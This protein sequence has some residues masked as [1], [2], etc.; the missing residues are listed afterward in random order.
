MIIEHSRIGCSEYIFIESYQ[1]FC[2]HYEALEQKFL[3]KY[4][5]SKNYVPKSFPCAFEVKEYNEHL[6]RYGFREYLKPC[7]IT[8]A[9]HHI[10]DEWQLMIN[11]QQNRINEINNFYKN[12]CETT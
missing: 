6:Y 7:D 12:F 9:Y 5:L 8:K 4:F 2:S 11:R 3:D 1:E 10:V